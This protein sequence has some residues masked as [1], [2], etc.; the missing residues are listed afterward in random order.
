MKE[1]QDIMLKNVTIFVHISRFSCNSLQ[2]TT[3]KLTV[4]NNIDYFQT[5][6]WDC[7]HY[8]FVL[9]SHYH[10]LHPRNVSNVSISSLSKHRSDTRSS[11][12]ASH[13]CPARGWAVSWVFKIYFTFCQN[14]VW[15]APAAANIKQRLV[16]YW[17]VSVINTSFKIFYPT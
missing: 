9:G 17:A 7:Y 13:Y 3:F 11:N 8:Q 5:T 4:N 12:N 16:K 6:A 1:A 14:N 2:S 15:N 10:Y